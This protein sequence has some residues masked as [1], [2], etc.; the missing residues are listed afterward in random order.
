MHQFDELD[1]WNG[2][3]EE[4]IREAQNERWARS[5]RQDLRAQK[6]AARSGYAIRWL[7]W[8]RGHHAA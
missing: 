8:A 7:L 1:L 3:R 2:R 6:R 5:L 4:L